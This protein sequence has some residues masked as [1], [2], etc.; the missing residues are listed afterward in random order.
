MRK[1]DGKKAIVTGEREGVQGP[2]IVACF[3]EAGVDVVY[4]TTECF[5]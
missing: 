4:S 2:A 3:K 1:F 5:V